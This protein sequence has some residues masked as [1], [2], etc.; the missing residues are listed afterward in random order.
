MA[1]PGL[2]GGAWRVGGFALLAAAAVLTACTTTVN[3]TGI[4][5]QPSLTPT[6][7]TSTAA[8]TPA[9]S[10]ATP[11][12]T[13]PAPTAVSPPPQCPGGT[14]QIAAT[15]GLQNGYE[16]LLRNGTSTTA[17]V[18][19]VVELT[20]RGVP[21]AWFVADGE[22]PAHIACSITNQ[23]GS[24]VVVNEVGAHG[25]DAIAFVFTGTALQRGD[26]VTASTPEMF[27]RDLNA[28]GT[29][30]A[31]GLQNDYTPDYATGKVQW[32]TWTSNGLHFTS[33]GCG[34]KSSVAPPRPTTLQ[35]GPC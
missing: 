33:T 3:G 18:S 26:T 16:I 17:P 28:D 2:R 31:E 7:T 14:C 20:Q 10:S 34:P 6:P 30:D 13:A 8:T 5:R 22:Q 1:R 35:T 9:S 32:Q 23:Q 19:S 27:P 24:C 15:I 25:S 11:T 4:A 12:P 29:I 21:V